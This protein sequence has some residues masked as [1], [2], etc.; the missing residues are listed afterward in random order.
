MFIND[1]VCEMESHIKFFVD[2]T[3]WS[4]VIDQPEILV[5]ALQSNIDEITFNLAKTESFLS[6]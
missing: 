5:L 1:V 4:L 3:S 2:D 6:K